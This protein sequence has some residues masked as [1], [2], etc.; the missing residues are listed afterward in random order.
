MNEHTISYSIGKGKVLELSEPVSD[1]ET[2]AQ[3]IRRLLGTQNALLSLWNGLTTVAVPYSEPDGVVKEL[4]LV[5]YAEDPLRLQVQVKGSFSSVRYESPEHPC[6]ES[7]PTVKNNGFTEFVIP[8]LHIAGRV[9]LKAS[10]KPDARPT[11]R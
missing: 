8:D 3:D 11:S 10:P 6:C 5:N 4:E 1:P 7:L 9:H 2:F